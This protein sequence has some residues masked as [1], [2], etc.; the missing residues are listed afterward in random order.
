MFSESLEITLQLTIGSERFTVPAG[1][2]KSFSLDL[3][4]YGFFGRAGFGVFSDESKDEMLDPFVT[5]DLIKVECSVIRVINL[6][7]DKEKVEPLFV[8]GYVTQKAIREFDYGAMKKEKIL[9]RYYEIHFQDIPGV[10]WHQ[11]YPVRLYTEKT[12][13]DILKDQEVEGLTLDIDQGLLDEKKMM[14][15][16]GLEKKAFRPSFYDF[17]IWLAQAANIYPVYDYSSGKLTLLKEKTGGTAADIF[18]PREVGDMQVQFPEALRHDIQILNVHSES[19]KKMD[20][21]QDSSD[22]QNV[23]GITQNIVMRTPIEADLESRKKTGNR[24]IKAVPADDGN[25]HERVS[26]P[27]LFNR[28]HGEVR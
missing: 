8:S 17:L 18:R 15:F 11:H 10:L 3:F 6:K 24:Q 27:N 25:K 13:S 28:E 4:S 22:K 16:L 12:I 19:F 2:I 5:H 20:I 26:F 23:A 14:L 9:E 1:N 7:E 21:A